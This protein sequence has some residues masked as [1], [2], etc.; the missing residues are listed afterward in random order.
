VPEP[1]GIDVFGEARGRLGLAEDPPFLMA[2]TTTVLPA[3]AKIER[4]LKTE[5]AFDS[6]IGVL[7]GTLTS[8]T[9]N[10]GVGTAVSLAH[11][12]LIDA[13]AVRVIHR[14]KE[15]VPER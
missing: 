13:V 1:A 12:E 6:L 5:E 14:L 11:P 7:T 9:K 10:T 8:E 4:L 15:L 2:V 3:I